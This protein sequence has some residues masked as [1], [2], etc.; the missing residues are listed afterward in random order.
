MDAV[1][2]F[3]LRYR[4]LIVILC[5]S[6]AV[7]AETPAARAPGAPIEAAH[8]PQTARIYGQL[9]LSF[10]RNGGQAGQQVRYLARGAGYS[11]LLEENDAV[12][13]LS[14]NASP[15]KKAS[16]MPGQNTEKPEIANSS[17]DTLQMKLIG[18]NSHAAVAGEARLPG[19]VNYFVGNDP[20][21]WLSAIPT[22]Q[23]VK[24]SNVYPG[25][26][27][28][29]YG[30]R[31]RL[32]FDFNLAPGADPRS[33]RLRFAG[34]RRLQVDEDGSLMVF[35]AHGKVSFLE[36]VI[37]QPDGE[38][39]KRPV[40]GS[41]RIG[42]N[43]TVGFALGAYDHSKPLLIDPILNYSTYLGPNSYAYAIAVDS[44]G[45]AYVA[46]FAGL[47]MP[48]TAGI[49]PNAPT[50]NA[51]G[52]ETAYVAKLNSAGT[53]IVYCTYLGGSSDD[54]AYGIAV[55]A[56]GNAY[57]G[58]WTFSSDFPVTKGA[59]QTM[60]HDA[61]GAGFVTAINSTGAGLI[62]STFLGGNTSTQVDAI[63]ADAGGDAYVTGNTSDFNFP[64]T[65][66]TFQASAKADYD[67]AP[68]GF[69]TKLNPSGNAL[70]YSSFLGGTG[71]DYPAAI[72]LDAKGDVYIAG[73]T[74]S[75]DFATTP[76]AF[77]T[78]NR[79]GWTGFVTQVNPAA[80][81]LI[82]S[83]YLGGQRMDEA[84]GIA[85]D[86]SGNAYVTGYA[87]SADFPVTTGVF[88]PK[89]NLGS[90]ARAQNAFIT[91]LNPSG[92]G[93]IYS[94]YLGGS[95]NVTGGA[96]LDVG[97]G[98]AVDASGNA[99]VAGATTD[100]DFPVTTGA[101]EPDNLAQLNS[102]DG[103]AFLAKI[104][105]TASHIL[106]A[107][108]LSGTGD[109]SGE[110]CDCARGM[111][112]GANGNVY[113]GGFAM[114]Q[115]FPTTS[116]AYQ[117]ASGNN[118]L[119]PSTFVTEFNTGEM[120]AL[121]ITTTA[122]TSS[123][124]GQEYGQPVTFTATVAPTS[125]STPIG[126]VGFSILMPDDLPLGMGMGPWTNVPLN[127]SGVATYTTSALMTGQTPVVA[128][129]L[130]D[131]KNAPSS[132]IITETVTQIPT[133][134]TITSSANPVPYG[135]PVTFTVKVLEKA[136]GN[137]ANGYIQSSF[138]QVNLDNSGQ[139]VLADNGTDL[140]VGDT[141]VWASFY[142]TGPVLADQPSSASMVETVTS[143][144]T[145]AAPTFS[146]PAGTY[147]SF[148]LVTVND[149]T[150]N[151]IIYYSTNGGTPVAG[152]AGG[153]PAGSQVTN[154][155][156]TETIKAIAQ[157]PGSAA[158]TVASAD[159]VINIQ[160]DFAF[161]LNPTSLTIYNGG[162]G[163]A[164][165]LVSAIDGFTGSVSFACS[166]L[167]AGAS[168]SFSPTSATPGGSSTLTIS[169]AASASNRKHPAELP[170]APISSLALALGC[171]CIRRKWRQGASLAAILFVASVCSLCACGGTGSGSNG[172]GGHS[173]PPATST[174]TITGSSGSLSHSSTLTLTVN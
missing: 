107:T 113:L 124:T 43:H 172:D 63:V 28:T 111:A 7:V 128:Y 115:D 83:T 42:R 55:D 166:G 147:T 117:T 2:V 54:V 114:S 98:I 141:K 145:T 142:P 4:I 133:T 125:G 103:S 95:K 26:D 17:A 131:A 85:V 151:A 69:V 38:N 118:G 158:S 6:I 70:V 88:Q 91:K 160:P 5:S 50:K 72:A 116:G 52:E 165:I 81:A 134:A 15:L 27:L 149:T 100:I 86:T 150:P 61:N 68:S 87:N 49:E 108:Y 79:S 154:V 135:Q 126:T 137:P 66:G 14:H 58:G 23:R 156:V 73:Y 155:M 18:V 77:Q 12:L 71:G 44:A 164:G 153:V 140:S 78:V 64:T 56:A 57:V 65:S 109:E 90:F 99:Y 123:I 32:E 104:D 139:A 10:E 163:T 53:A 146:P 59:F 112:M 161:T 97:E 75:S 171:W 34:A 20:A 1:C 168:C 21:K 39:R 162:T 84:Q 25:I 46:G 157:A 45:E 35:T 138:G 148:Q 8:H 41:F 120:T 36:P 96:G 101:F 47:G 22:F 62:Y 13:S 89:L 136:T 9:P 170:F 121:P 119:G 130:G 74:L 67:E 102:A 11:L 82:Y 33:I 132:G 3:S 152:G 143:T 127:G 48:T 16:R 174:V 106:Y 30:N 169:V 92:T 76:G 37:Y 80:T 51:G 159:Y 94:T 144:T 105:P 129:Y 40:T 29:Y 173:T 24:Y 167:P 122:I 110:S 19:T 60:N 31:Q 93:L